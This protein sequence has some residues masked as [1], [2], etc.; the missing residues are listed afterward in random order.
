[1][2]VAPKSVR[3]RIILCIGRERKESSPVNTALTGVV[4]TA[5]MASR[6]PVP[7]LPKSST[8]D[9]SANPPV[10][11][12]WTV[13]SPSPERSTSAPRSRMAAPVRMTSPPSRSPEIRVAPTES[14]PRISERC[15]I[16]LSPGT[17][18]SPTNG[19]DLCA[20]RGIISWVVGHGISIRSSAS[21]CSHRRESSACLQ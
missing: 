5:P 7:E 13:H 9:G 17:K 4:E 1:M 3:G 8:F 20:S 10:P 14:A 21:A 11:N 12:P 2:Q 16:D 15:E 18:H 19:P 6:T